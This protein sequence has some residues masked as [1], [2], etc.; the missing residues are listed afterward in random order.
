[1]KNGVWGWHLFHVGTF[2]SEKFVGY[3][4]RRL[5]S[6]KK[7]GTPTTASPVYHVADMI[8]REL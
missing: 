1:M 4:L 6:K 8:R 3:Y 7:K 2:C 5:D